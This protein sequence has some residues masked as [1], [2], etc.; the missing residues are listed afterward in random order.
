[1]RRQESSG[2]GVIRK[3]VSVDEK[4]L[5]T[6]LMGLLDDPTTQED[7]LSLERDSAQTYLDVVQHLLDR[8]S[9]TG[10]DHLNSEAKILMLKLSEKCNMLPSSFFVTGVRG[11]D[12]HPTFSGGF[13]DIYRASYYGMTVA[14]KLRRRFVGA[15]ESEEQR[16]QRDYIREAFIWQCL[17]HPYIAPMLGIDRES[18]PSSLCLVSPW[19]ENGT[20]LQYLNKRDRE[21]KDLPKLLYQIAQ[22]MEYLHSKHIVHGDVRGANILITPDGSPC[23]T[24]FGFASFTNYSAATTDITWL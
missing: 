1:M 4:L 5:L 9:L 24:D 16:A 7:V 6:D 17:K 2:V 21:D 19:E 8:D 12:E 13:S 18:F 14:L 3:A 22:G 20:V 10:K 11:S 23:L 15:S